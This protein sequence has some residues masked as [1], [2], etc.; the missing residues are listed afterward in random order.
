LRLAILTSEYPPLTPYDGGI[1]TLY[2]SLAPSL[3]ALAPEVHVFALSHDREGVEEHDGVRVH[4]VRPG[5]RIGRKLEPVAWSRAAAHAVRREGPF[6]LV[7]TPEWFG[8]GYAYSRRPDAGPL[9]T[10]LCTSLAQVVELNGG[11]PRFPR[12]IDRRIQDHLE[13]RQTERSDTILTLSQAVLDWAGRLWDLADVPARQVPSALDVASVRALGDGPA[14]EY[15]PE[16][17]PRVVFFGRPEP[18]KGVDVLVQAMSDVWDRFPAAPL[19]MLGG[20]DEPMISRLRELAGRNAENIHVLGF[21]PRADLLASIR[22]ADVVALPSL[23]ETFTVAGLEAMALG[24]P[25]VLT[26][27]GGTPEF[28]T[29]GVDALLV[30]PSDPRALGKAILRVLEDTDLR[31]RLGKQAA[32]TADRYDVAAVAPRYVSCFEDVLAAR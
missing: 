9:L 25:V 18:L 8:S 29:D 22:A 27:V 32:K 21:V 17:S 6:D 30:P 2:V 5:A 23:W 20:D 12:Q 16:G 1:G 11:W 15:L 10:Q 7:M 19:A 3:A 4:L 28:C 31:E 26:A 14:P 13:R 24:K